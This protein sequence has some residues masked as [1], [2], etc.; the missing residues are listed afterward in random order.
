MEIAFEINFQMMDV[1]DF[2]LIYTTKD[3]AN[4]GDAVTPGRRGDPRAYG[5]YTRSMVRLTPR[6]SGVQLSIGFG[7]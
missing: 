3:R 6:K 4:S 1:P 5:A 7:F 2:L